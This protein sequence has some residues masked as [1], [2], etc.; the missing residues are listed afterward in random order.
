MAAENDYKQKIEEYVAKLLFQ[1]DAR[2]ITG[3]DSSKK[4]LED[5]FK[6]AEDLESSI[7]A[8]DKPPV[9]ASI[10]AKKNTKAQF[11]D[12]LSLTVDDS[13]NFVL[14]YMSSLSREKDFKINDI[15][16]FPYIY[17]FL[18][19][20]KS[21]Q[22][23]NTDYSSPAF[24]NIVLK[25]VFSLISLP[26]QVLSTQ[27]GVAST[28]SMIPILLEATYNHNISDYAQILAE[29]GS[30]S[31]Q[32]K[33]EKMAEY[34]KQIQQKQQEL[35]QCTDPEKQKTLLSDIQAFAKEIASIGLT[36]EED[37]ENIT[38]LCEVVDNTAEN[39]S[40]ATSKMTVIVEDG[41]AQ[42]GK[43]S[44]KTVREVGD[45]A[46]TGQKATQNQVTGEALEKAAQGIAVKAY[47]KV[48]KEQQ[49]KEAGNSEAS[50]NDDNTV[51]AD[52]EDIK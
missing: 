6:L 29:D 14:R 16:N 52:Y 12:S 43:L 23:I 36:L 9:Y 35:A 46:K 30:L 11:K 21:I 18:K 4:N 10:K 17:M 41:Q 1:Y 33:Q 5:G 7:K 47:E 31:Y 2:T 13:S 48:Q 15:Q 51:D 34:I 22:N 37:N 49:A 8:G 45:V 44:K 20:E 26:P 39:V 19:N 3:D 25:V 24:H 42:I 38:T 32:D 27:E 28:K 50:T 40:E